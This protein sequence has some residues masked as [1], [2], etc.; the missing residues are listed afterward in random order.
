[1]ELFIH[2]DKYNNTHVILR[3]Q[4]FRGVFFGFGVS[5]QRFFFNYQIM[6]L[7]NNYVVASGYLKF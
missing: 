5:K 6:S 2:L 7:K 3:V 1:M 4:Y